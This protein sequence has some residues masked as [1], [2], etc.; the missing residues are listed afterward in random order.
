MADDAVTW[1]GFEQADEALAQRVLERMECHRHAIMAPLRVDGSP[2]LSGMEAPIRSGNLWLAMT[3]GSRKAVD[4]SR[5]P[6]FSL[7]SAPDAEDLG[8]GDARIDGIA[9]LADAAQQDEFLAGHRYPVDDPS[10]M[11]LYVAMITGVVLVRVCEDS[12][13]IES[14]TPAAGRDTHRIQ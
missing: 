5:D 4:L 12:L 2:R 6:R 10:I 3:P 13:L 7:H 14:W 9:Q 8:E 1:A 11:V